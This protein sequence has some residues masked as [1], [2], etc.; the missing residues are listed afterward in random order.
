MDGSVVGVQKLINAKCV[1]TKIES[2]PALVGR[3][4]GTQK[5]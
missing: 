3:T 5:R 2:G 4:A 1:E